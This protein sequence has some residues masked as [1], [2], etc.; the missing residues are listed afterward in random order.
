MGR[1][2]DERCAEQPIVL[3]EHANRPFNSEAAIHFGEAIGGLAVKRAETIIFGNK[4]T[5]RCPA[6][7]TDRLIERNRD[8]AEQAALAL[9]ATGDVGGLVRQHDA[10]KRTDRAAAGIKRRQPGDQVGQQFLAN[11]SMIGGGKTQLPDQPASR[12]IGFV[13]DDLEIS[14]VSR[15][16]HRAVPRHR[17]L[18]TGRCPCSGLE[19]CPEP[20]L[21]LS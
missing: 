6:G 14:G 8:G 12:N 10:R 11:V 4:I 9:D 15:S 1:S 7:A 2:V 19:T 13:L 16:R 5:A 18:M 3:G 17:V 21:N 20:L